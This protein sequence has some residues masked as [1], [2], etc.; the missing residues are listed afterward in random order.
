MSLPKEPEFF[1]KDEIYAKGW[2]WYLSL[3]ADAGKE[4]A[5]G[6]GSTSYTKV[7][8]FVKVPERIAR[9]IPHARLI[10][11]VRHPLE[12]I[13]SHWMH[14]VKHGDT[15]SFK[16]MLKEY[17]NLIDTSRYWFQIQQYR[18]YFGDDQILVLFFEELKKNPEGVLTQCFKFLGVDPEVKLVNPAEHRHATGQFKVESD[19]LRSMREN[20]LI[21]L[22][23]RVLPAPVKNT[24]K[25]K[26]EIRVDSRPEWSDDLRRWV[27]SEISGDVSTFL[28]YYGKPADYWDLSAEKKSRSGHKK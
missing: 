12:R 19:L 18:K 22:A 1:C 3:F 23:S 24:L 5:I 27:I 26:F 17:P 11:I 15:R 6:E 4:S 8:L 16:N 28:D 21:R 13:E 20:N 7:P 25:A 9:H 14:R 2:E 10:Y